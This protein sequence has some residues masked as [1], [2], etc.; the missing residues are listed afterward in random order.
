MAQ[1]EDLIN[2]IADARLRG[3]IAAEVGKLKARKKFGRGALPAA[4][5]RSRAEGDN[6]EAGRSGHQLPGAAEKAAGLANFGRRHAGAFGRIEA[7]RVEQGRIQRLR[8]HQESVRDKV[9]KVTDLRHLAEL[10][11]QHG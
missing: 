11:A 4:L 9:L 8:L 10:Y 3:Q 5:R 1:L 2:E 7:I 6:R